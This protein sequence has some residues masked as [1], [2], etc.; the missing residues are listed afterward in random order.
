[1]KNFR[2]ISAL[3]LAAALSV[4]SL[5]GCNKKD[6]DKKASTINSGGSNYS[7]VSNVGEKE[8][9]VAL[10]EATSVNST[11]YKLNRVID[12]GET[13]DGVKYIYLDVTLKN[14]SNTDFTI[15]GHNN[16]YL[17]LE[18]GTEVRDHVRADL[19]AT[20]SLNGYQAL[21]SIPAGG[22]FTGYIG[23]CV[24]ENVDSFKVG[25]FPTADAEN[26]KEN[27]IFCDV[28]SGDIVAAPEGMFTK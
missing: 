11:S 19:F 2:R 13:K 26:N 9:S 22:E 20:K 28:K 25:F 18:D 12:S 15:S 16:F 8:Y 1:M 21:E 4:A 10:D 24:A 23:F 5:S 3:I 27:V 7:D 14:E 17:I 6:K